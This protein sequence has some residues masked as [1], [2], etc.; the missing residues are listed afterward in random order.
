MKN[1]IK[2]DEDLCV[3]CN[4]CVKA[5]PIMSANIATHRQGRIL[6][7]KIDA[8]KCISCG[9]CVK[10]CRHD[11]RRYVDDTGYVMKNI[12]D[13]AF[14]VDPAAVI[15]LKNDGMDL[16]SYFRRNGAKAIYDLNLGEE[17]AAYLNC[18]YLE[19][20]PSAN[21]IS[22]TCPSVVDFVEK[23][24]PELIPNL[25]P[26]QSP[27]LCLAIYLRKY[28]GY[29]GKI[30]AISSCTARIVEFNETG[31]IINANVTI[32]HIMEYFNG[33]S[34][35]P[36]N[37]EF[38]FDEING[39][40]GRSYPVPIGLGNQIRKINPKISVMEATGNKKAFPYLY[41]YIDTPNNKRPRFLDA[42]KCN[43]GC[44]SGSGGKGK[45]NPI[46]MFVNIEDHVVNTE[47]DYSI[48]EELNSEDF[49]RSYQ[50][51]IADSLKTSENDIEYGFRLLHKETNYDRTFDCN[52]CGY[53]S[54]REMAIAVANSINVAENCHQYA[55]IEVYN[56]R[57]TIQE[58]TR[59]VKDTFSNMIGKLQE[60]IK[61]SESNIS[62][63]VASSKK[64]EYISGS[65]T[66]LESSCEDIE[67]TLYSIKQ[68]LKSFK[69]MTSTIDSV[70][71]QT[72][73]LSLNA[74]IEAARAGVKGKGFAVVADEVRA[75][76]AKT[77]LTTTDIGTSTEDL[78]EI[79]V[80]SDEN[81]NKMNEELVKFE[82]AVNEI[83]KSIENTNNSS[84][85]INGIILKIINL[86]DEVGS[87]LNH[88]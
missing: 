13:Y 41:K 22:Q 67:T 16:L 72:N 81:I 85:E 61:I 75:L 17:I 76:S 79:V 70:A 49:Y 3:G 84:E 31:G 87:N 26:I 12:S 88:F 86:A 55:A 57:Q 44:V 64:V 34:I 43:S 4:A 47:S 35:P 30:A 14:I 66:N 39:I 25:S 48:M 8:D 11:A 7:A 23:H 62:D 54:C 5:C 15:T 56:A 19:E 51:R 27:M 1:I 2:V 37:E 58:V 65:I 45:T 73:I 52:S 28:L 6:I 42:L 33:K 63:A 53:N 9:S 32:K 46:E 77:K 29:R 40:K 36:A 82:N 74:S 60:A 38:V 71:R 68:T 78:E 18:K 80:T 69:D 10:A 24:I 83:S 21:I 20:N 50:N 59:N